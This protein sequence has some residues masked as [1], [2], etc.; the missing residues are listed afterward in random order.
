[1][2]RRAT[3]AARF[4]ER[5][6]VGVLS[7]WFQGSQ[8]DT[9]VARLECLRWCASVFRLCLTVRHVHTFRGATAHGF[10]ARPDGQ[11]VIDGSHI[12]L[13]RY[14]H[15]FMCVWLQMD[16]WIDLLTTC[17]HHSELQVIT[18]L[19]LISTLYK[20]LHAKSSPAYCVLTSRSLSTSSNDGDSSASR[21]H[22][23]TRWLST[24]PIESSLHTLP[25]NSL[26]PLIQLPSL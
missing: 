19:S 1:M 14:C 8:L 24:P 25:Y 15:F 13:L 26:W 10:T 12:V 7:S 21:A 17:T 16:W 18:A 23:V 22:F 5:R 4:V 6:T 2:W 11:N 20:S 3:E 9:P